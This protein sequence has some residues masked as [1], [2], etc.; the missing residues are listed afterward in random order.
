[1]LRLGVSTM[2]VVAD[3]STPVADRAANGYRTATG[4]MAAFRPYG[5]GSASIWISFEDARKDKPQCMRSGLKR[6]TAYRAPKLCVARVTA[7]LY[8]DLPSV[9]INRNFQRRHPLQNTAFV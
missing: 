1:M 8:R 4:S 7:G 3:S 2:E 9:I 6:P 5:R